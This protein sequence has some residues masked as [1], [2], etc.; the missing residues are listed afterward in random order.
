M[1]SSDY[2]IAV[3]RVRID[4]EVLFM[5]TV[6]EFPDLVLYEESA[7]AAYEDALDAIGELVALA[8]EMGHAVPVPS[9]RRDDEYS[10]RM[11]FRPGKRL[12]REI[13][14]AAE[15]NGLS[16]NQWLCNTVARAVTAS[17]LLSPG[18]ARTSLR[19]PDSKKALLK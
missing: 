14:A 17:D 13:A 2:K 19:A 6:R 8:K 10:G 11:T 7:V 16:Q 4:G 12:H 9:V 1:S 5:A 18:S 3:Q 15:A